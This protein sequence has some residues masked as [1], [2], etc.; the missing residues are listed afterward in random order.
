M[1]CTRNMSL[2]CDKQSRHRF[3]PWGPITATPRQRLGSEISH[4]R[5][6]IEDGAASIQ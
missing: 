2:L 6:S 5:A 3:M 4:Y 1:G